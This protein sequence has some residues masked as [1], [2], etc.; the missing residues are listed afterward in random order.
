MLVHCRT[1]KPV[2]FEFPK[3]VARTFVEE[4]TGEP[5]EFTEGWTENYQPNLCPSEVSA[6]TRA[7]ADLCLV[8]LNSN[9]FVY[10]E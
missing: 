3:N 5:F 1:T 8:L 4:M 6:Q 10:L 9:E 7:L 2:D